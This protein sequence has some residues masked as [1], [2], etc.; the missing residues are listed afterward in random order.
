MTE[1]RSDEKGVPRSST[2][3]AAVNRAKKK[4]H[5]DQLRRDA[6]N[7]IS[8]FASAQYL[9]TLSPVTDGY[10]PNGKW[11]KTIEHGRIYY[12]FLA[13]DYL[14]AGGGFPMPRY[15]S[16]TWAGDPGTDSDL[17]RAD[18]GDI[19][20]GV[21][22]GTP[23][24][25][26]AASK[27][28]IG[29][30]TT[31]FVPSGPGAAVCVS[32]RRIVNDDNKAPASHWGHGILLFEEDHSE[33]ES[34]LRQCFFKHKELTPDA[35]SFLLRAFWPARTYARIYNF[36]GGHSAR[37]GAFHASRIDAVCSKI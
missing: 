26:A 28:P 4:P 19:V 35:L 34:L 25:D 18:F 20:S 2:S 29:A 36:G 32:E 14:N 23:V 24:A 30:W 11:K 1:L 15:P 7:R 33:L 13:R 31:T 8:K 27:L 5:P 17:S 10:P 12:R 21:Y 6:S 9:K 3:L 22:R 37:L 16:V